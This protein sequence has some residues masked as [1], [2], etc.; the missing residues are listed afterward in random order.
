M[1]KAISLFRA[2]ILKTHSIEIAIAE[3]KRKGYSQND[4]IYVLMQVLKINVADADRWVR[5][6]FIWNV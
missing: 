5:N 4:T 6:S 1:E 3:L 2:V